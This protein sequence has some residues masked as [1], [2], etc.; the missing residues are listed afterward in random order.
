MR[1]LA[2]LSRFRHFAAATVLASLAVPAFAATTLSPRQCNDYPFVKLDKP[3]THRQLQNELKE[4]ESVG[5]DPSAG[6]Q[7]DYPS[8]LEQAE[9]K[10]QV[11]YRQDCVA[12][13]N[14]TAAV[15]HS[16]SV[17]SASVAQQ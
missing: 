13:A 12:T 1:K 7:D 6:D 10:L 9:A 8:D 15:T 2:R 5:Y 14:R 16:T 4:L 11:K 17:T 3:V